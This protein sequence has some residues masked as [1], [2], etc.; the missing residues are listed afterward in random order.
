MPII[1][2]QF[3]V[4]LGVK[5]EVRLRATNFQPTCRALGPVDQNHISANS[6]LMH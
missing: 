1:I 5:V 2:T 3:I 4:D 6:E